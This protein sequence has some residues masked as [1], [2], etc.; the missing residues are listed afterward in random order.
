MYGLDFV[1]L[2]LNYLEL[3]K[4]FSSGSDAEEALLEHCLQDCTHELHGYVDQQMQK[5]G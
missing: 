2:P 3:A 4:L 1:L 5:G